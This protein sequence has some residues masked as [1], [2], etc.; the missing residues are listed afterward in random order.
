ME[1]GYRERVDAKRGE[2]LR[3]RVSH[4]P[5]RSKTEAMTIQL[6]RQKP[7]LRRRS[8]RQ[9]RMQLA[10]AFGAG[11]AAGGAT[12]L[13]L[14]SVSGRRR[15]R[16][17]DRTAGSVRR[18]WRRAARRGR[19]ARGATAGAVKRVRHRSETPRELDDV[20]LARKVESELFRDP[21]VPKGQISINAQRGVV[22]L[23]GEVP[24]AEMLS[25]LVGRTRRIQGV[26]D[27]ESLLHLHG[28]DAP[29]HQ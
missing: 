16:S 26:R 9:Q 2:T 19:R 25:D 23:R 7:F 18:T 11:A 10:G 14:D 22:Q 4:R 8:P 13:F 3:R 5:E 28:V 12:L 15:R 20:T 27:V 29:M 21:S 17:T 6:T 1:R 24:S